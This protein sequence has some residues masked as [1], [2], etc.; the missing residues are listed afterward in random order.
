MCP[1]DF[2]LFTDTSNIGTSV[3]VFVNYY[4]VAPNVLFEFDTVA[5]PMRSPFPADDFSSEVFKDF[6]SNSHLLAS[7]GYY[8]RTG[9]RFSVCFLV[10]PFS[11][12]I[13]A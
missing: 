6:C 5:L 11:F 2:L 12:W 4:P 10:S 7:A 13:P 8:T 9:Q 3:I 1:Q